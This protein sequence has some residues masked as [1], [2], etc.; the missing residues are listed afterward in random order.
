MYPIQKYIQ[1]LQRTDENILGKDNSKISKV[2]LFGGHSFNHVKTISI[3][4]V[5]IEFIYFNQ[6]F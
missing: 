4:T 1:K 6:T 3:L 5:S 2:L